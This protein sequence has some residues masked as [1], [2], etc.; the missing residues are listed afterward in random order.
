MVKE[1]NE[2]RISQGAEYI[3]FH[4]QIH[5]ILAERSK[6]F[7]KIEAKR[8]IEF[9]EIMNAQAKKMEAA[10]GKFSNANR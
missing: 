5:K 2:L 6:R 1:L 7:Q 4:Y 8:H 3:E 9:Q 10:G